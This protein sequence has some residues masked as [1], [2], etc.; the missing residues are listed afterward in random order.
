VRQGEGG[1]EITSRELGSNWDRGEMSGD[2]SRM[3]GGRSSP[4]PE[5]GRTGGER[6]AAGGVGM[7]PARLGSGTGGLGEGTS[8]AQLRRVGLGGSVDGLGSGRSGARVVYG[9]KLLMAFV[10]CLYTSK[11]LYVC[12][13]NSN[14]KSVCE[15]LK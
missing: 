3:R 15:N 1:L 11:S 2:S 4:P 12:A 13:A 6:R 5:S 8:S 10:V 7:R 9:S 14:Y